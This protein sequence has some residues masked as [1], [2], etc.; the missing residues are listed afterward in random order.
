MEFLLY[1][2]LL[3]FYLGH[4]SLMRIPVNWKKKIHFSSPTQPMSIIHLQHYFGHVGVLALERV[5]ETQD[6]WILSCHCLG[7]ALRK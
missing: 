3:S 4:C 5:T 1:L 2:S 6:T 7:I